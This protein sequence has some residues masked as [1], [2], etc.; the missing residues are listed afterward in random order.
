MGIIVHSAS[1]ILFVIG[2][3]A[4]VHVTIVVRHFA[5]SMFDVI[6]PRP[7]VLITI[8]VV[9]RTFRIPHVIIPL[10]L[11]TVA[12]VIRHFTTTFLSILPTAHVFVPVH[13]CHL[14]V[15]ITLVVSPL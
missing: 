14:A 13:V 10:P 2:P 3:V 4:H 15:T 11:V 8:D 7:T 6:L 1:S 12:V 9:H 5:H